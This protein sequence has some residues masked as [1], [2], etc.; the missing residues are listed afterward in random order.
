MPEGD[1]IM[2]KN[3]WY[4][5]KPPTKYPSVFFVVPLWLPLPWYQVNQHFSVVTPP[6]RPC[7][8]PVLWCTETESQTLE[9][10]TDRCRAWAERRLWSPA[11]WKWTQLRS[12]KFR[13]RVAL[14]N[15]YGHFPI[16]PQ[17]SHVPTAG[18]TL[19][20]GPASVIQAIGC[21]I[22]PFPPGARAHQAEDGFCW[23][24]TCRKYFTIPS[25]TC[26]NV[27]NRYL[28][29]QR[30]MQLSRAVPVLSRGQDIPLPLT[31]RGCWVDRAE[32]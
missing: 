28:K 23:G 27:E 7:S 13:N 19:M 31:H 5:I 17:N 6:L 8:S 32:V 21:K 12:K 16:Q 11:G 29:L 25:T 26:N 24:A 22:T 30:S 2:L 15:I 4:K 10:D 9:R 3:I 18:Y 1:E 20:P 14:P